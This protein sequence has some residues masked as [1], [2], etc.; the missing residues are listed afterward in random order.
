MTSFFTE[1]VNGNSIGNVASNSSILYFISE[2]NKSSIAKVALY[3]LSELIL[4]ENA[5]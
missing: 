5:L 2:P 3:K 1:A 4:I